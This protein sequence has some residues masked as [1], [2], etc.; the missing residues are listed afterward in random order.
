MANF[1]AVML[2]GIKLYS[3]TAKGITH[4]KAKPFDSVVENLL[5]ILFQPVLKVSLEGL[6]MRKFRNEVAGFNQVRCQ[7]SN[8][9]SANI[10]TLISRGQS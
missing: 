3:N 9:L 8:E 7:L 2:L 4:A 10:I 1:Y 6:F 5:A